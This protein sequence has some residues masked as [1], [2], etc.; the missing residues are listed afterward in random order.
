VIE[1]TELRCMSR[2]P[3]EGRFAA[4]YGS[5]RDISGWLLARWEN[6]AW[7]P[8]LGNKL[9]EGAIGWVLLPLVEKPE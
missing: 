9:P 6:G 8:Q 2:H 5:D 7:K 3:A 1:G 4:I